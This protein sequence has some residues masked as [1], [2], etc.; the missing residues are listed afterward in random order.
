MQVPAFP[1][2]SLYKFLALAGLA[3]FFIIPGF[4]V[5]QVSDA[6]RQSLEA[7]VEMRVLRVETE[8][9][10]ADLIH[11]RRE[12]KSQKHVMYRIRADTKALADEVR[13]AEVKTK[14]GRQSL[15]AMKELG[16][17]IVAL[18][19]RNKVLAEAADKLGAALER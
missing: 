8:S 14:R 7:L 4:Y 6:E 16:E 13:A 2:D 18:Q 10:S 5:S 15:A 19:D 12:A 11:L 1:T 17:K 3:G 9:R